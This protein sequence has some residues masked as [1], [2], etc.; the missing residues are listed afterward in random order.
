[1]DVIRD[2]TDAMQIR[3][4]AKLLNDAINKMSACMIITDDRGIVRYVNECFQETYGYR[5][6]ELQGKKM[7]VLNSGKHDNEFYKKLWGTVL[8]GDTFISKIINKTKEGRMLE[9]ELTIAPVISE[10]LKNKYFIGLYQD[11]SVRDKMIQTEKE[12][13]KK[14]ILLKEIHHRV[15]NNMQVID[16]LISMQQ[17]KFIDP[18]LIELFNEAKGRIKA[19]ALVHELIYSTDNLSH[20]K[21]RE[22]LSILVNSLITLYSPDYSVAYVDNIE[23]DEIN[24]EIAIPLGII[25]NELVT[26]TL[27]YA[28]NDSIIENKIIN[29]KVKKVEGE[30]LEIVYSDNGKGVGEIRNNSSKGGIGTKLIVSLIKQLK[31]KIHFVSEKGFIAKMYIPFK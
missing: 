10:E 18:K 23:D 1:M 27:K 28:F 16:S 17:S 7:N 19:M 20:L 14:E 21:L 12:L 25:I 26:N 24:L 22:Y 8:N 3:N 31:G 2:V 9:R 13:K 5:L 11:V 4:R 6:S 29:L 15:K 30:G